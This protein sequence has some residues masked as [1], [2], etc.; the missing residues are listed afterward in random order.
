MVEVQWT[1]LLTLAIVNIGATILSLSGALPGGEAAYI[2]IGSLG[3]VFGNGHALM[4]KK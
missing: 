1:K 3:Y 4:G 2:Y